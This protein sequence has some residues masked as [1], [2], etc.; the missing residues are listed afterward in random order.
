[1]AE[2]LQDW[3][4]NEVSKLEVRTTK[5]LSEYYFHRVETRSTPIDNKYMFTPADGVVMDVHESIRA[6]EPFIEAKGTKLTL[7]ELMQDDTIV[8]KY[9]VVSIFMTFYSQHQNYIP[10]AGNRVYHELP[11]LT[12]FNKPML[13]VEK[14]LLKGVINPEFQEDYLR[15]NGR[16]ISTIYSPKLQQDYHLIRL[17]DYDV[18]CFVNWIQ[19]EGDESMSYN[20]NARFGMITYG[21]QCVLAIPLHR[22]M[23]V[24]KF[25]I[26]PEATVG[27]YVKCKRD[28]L[29][30][31][32]YP[33]E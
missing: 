30:E 32:I 18:D 1:M 23:D 31:V 28:A 16:E 21:S 11:P 12:T 24:C 29:V 26:R 15:N 9:L 19:K 2:K 4:D 7:Q 6:D 14:G 17:G 33:G 20:Q 5:W 13:D 25:K 27:N 8:G 10:F 22:G 3:L